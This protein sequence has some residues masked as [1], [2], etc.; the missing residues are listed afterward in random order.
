MKLNPVNKN[1][2]SDIRRLYRSAFPFVERK[3]FSFLLRKARRGQ[4]EFFAIEDDT[5]L[6]LGLANTLFYKDMVMLDYFATA[7]E[8]RNGGMGTAVLALLKERYADRRLFGEIEVTDRPHPELEL[9][10]RRRNFYLRNGFVPV[11]MTV[12]AF[13]CEFEVI[14]TGK[15][16]SFSEYKEFYYKAIGPMAY[17]RVKLI[18]AASPR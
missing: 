2:I 17:G 1:N 18:K 10:K 4:G 15:P 9:R 6:F 8:R 14:S 13:S 11:G 3:P 5:G 12:R 16:I 7:P